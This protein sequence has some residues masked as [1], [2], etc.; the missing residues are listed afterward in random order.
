MLLADRGRG[1]G[2]LVGVRGRRADVH[3]RDVGA[4]R[5]HLEDQVLRLAGAADDLEP[6]VLE[7]LGEPLAQQ[8]RVLGDHDPHGISPTTSVP[9]PG[10]LSIHSCPPRASTRSARPRSP[11]PPPSDAPPEPSSATSIVSVPFSHVAAT[12]TCVACACFATFAS[13]SQATK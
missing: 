7:Q 4:V 2:A 8:H 6:L 3:D 10:G 5:A 1:A 11:V 9:P 13:A 12:V